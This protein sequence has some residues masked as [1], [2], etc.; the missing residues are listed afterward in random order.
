[1]KYV[2]TKSPPPD[3]EIKVSLNQ[4]DDGVYVTMDGYYVLEIKNTGKIKR[5]GCVPSYLGLST[6]SRG[7]VIFEN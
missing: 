7:R 3:D 1:M 2:T 6:D 4:D 5:V